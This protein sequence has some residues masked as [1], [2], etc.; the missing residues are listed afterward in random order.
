[1]SIITNIKQLAGNYFLK[2]DQ[3]VLERNK[4]ALSLTE[5]KSFAIVFEASK[6]E[7]VDL[8][9]KYVAYLKE[10]KKRIKVIG[11]LDSNSD[12]SFTYSKLEYEF[13]NKKDLVWY[14]KPHG[15][16]YNSF[17]A[18][19]FDVLIDLNLLDH[20]PL[21]YVVAMSKAKFKVGKYSEE[22][23]DIHDLLID[24]DEAKTFKYFLRQVDTYLGMINNG[25]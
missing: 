3:R 15:S 17:V 6:L 10:M 5:A 16:I 9:K 8:V 11:F 24:V 12:P 19:D 23:K 22:N 7:D 21:K 2:Q 20:F 14:L 13:F 1:M 25:R 4:T 18:E